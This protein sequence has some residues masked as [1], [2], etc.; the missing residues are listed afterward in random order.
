[1]LEV[2]LA[3][4]AVLGMAL[5]GLGWR[6]RIRHVG[7]ALI[8]QGGGVAILY[9]TLYAAFRLFSVI[10]SGLAFSLMVVVALAAA[11]LAVAQNALILA[12]IGFAGGFLAPLLTSSGAGS[13]ISLF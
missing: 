3:A 10:P 8:L 9:L 13:H 2:R 7:Y 5:L 12:V 4:V 11:V 6:L 1:P